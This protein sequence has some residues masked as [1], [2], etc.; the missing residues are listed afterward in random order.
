MENYSSVVFGLSFGLLER[1]KLILRN[2]IFSKVGFVIYLRAN[3]DVLFIFTFFLS[4]PRQLV[5]EI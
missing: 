5:T 1:A 2:R 3:R 4:T